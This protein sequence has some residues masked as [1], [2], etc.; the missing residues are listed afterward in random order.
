MRAHQ[1]QGRNRIEQECGTL[2]FDFVFF[3]LFENDCR[4]QDQVRERARKV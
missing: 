3:V 2:I 4:K 1:C